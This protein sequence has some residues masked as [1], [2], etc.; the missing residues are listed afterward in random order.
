MK[1]I[2]PYLKWTLILLFIAAAAA[3]FALFGSY[4]H[5]DLKKLYLTPIIGDPNGWEIYVIEDGQRVFLTPEE[6]L[7]IDLKRTYYISRTLTQEMRYEKYNGV[8]REK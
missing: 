4:S 1:K 3:V 6:L 8:V 7:E 2:V 5:T